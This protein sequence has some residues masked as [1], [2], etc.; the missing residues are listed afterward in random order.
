MALSLDVPERQCLIDF[1]DDPNGFLWH[2]RLLLKPTPV[3]GRW[4]VSTPDHSVEVCDLNAHRVVALE[5]NAP[6]P[7]NRAGQSYVF[8]PVSAQELEGLR[9]QARSLL[10]IMGV[11]SAG[12][13]PATAVS[14][15]VADP[16][17]PAFNEELPV[18]VTGDQDSFMPAPDNSIGMA[19]IDDEWV[20][21]AAVAPD[22][23]DAW[24]RGKRAGAGRDERLLGDERVGGARFLGMDD[25]VRLC[26]STSL[27]GWPFEGERLAP[28][29]V[30][31]MRATGYEWMSHHLDFV[32]KSGVSR[33][34]GVA[35]SHRRLSEAM[36]HFMCFDQL[37]VYNLAGCELL[38]RY[39]H[40]IETAVRRNPKNPDFS[41]Q[42]MLLS[43]GIDEF[44]GIIATRYSHWVSTVQRDQAQVLKQQRLYAEEQ[45]HAR[46]AA[47]GDGGGG[48]RSKDSEGRGGGPKG[49][50]GKGGGGA[51]GP[52][53][54]A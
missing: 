5:R 22:G 45:G 38:I 20:A 54:G 32:S 11:T 19:K 34:S 47:G 52:P 31:A 39:M 16:A 49:G 29:F 41:N 42:D 9:R 28:E 21:V 3:P 23:V 18:G 26:K 25:A 53:A 15:R 13:A 4:V 35:R 40:Q 30:Q 51:D 44:G 43:T 8:D 1:F 10:D 37:N 36:T 7:P 6:I 17:H 14:W 50:R 27:V 46:K 33:S 2:H 24:L 12:D 48:G